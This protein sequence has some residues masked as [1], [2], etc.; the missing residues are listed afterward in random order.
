MAVALTFNKKIVLGPLSVLVQDTYFDINNPVGG[1]PVQGNVS[2]MNCA[3][4]KLVQK[5]LRKTINLWTCNQCD[6]LTVWENFG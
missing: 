5:I 1:P 4:G 6:Q 3:L 2:M